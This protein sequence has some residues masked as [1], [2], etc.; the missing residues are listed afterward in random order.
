MVTH[1]KE[2]ALNDHEFEALLRGAQNIDDDLQSQE[3]TFVVYV[4][5][6]LGLRIGELTHMSSDWIN[7]RERMLEIPYR[8]DCTRGKD[9]GICGMC[10]QSAV[11]RA[12][13]SQLSLA[14]ARLK[15][16]QEQLLDSISLPGELQQQ[17]ETAHMLHI[18]SSLTEE[19]LERQIEK[20]LET[21]ATVDDADEVRSAL[22]EI[23]RQHQQDVQLTVDEAEDM[24]W[25]A[26]TENA[27]RSVPFA[28]APAVELTVEEYFDRFD[29]WMLSHSGVRRRLTKALQHANGL[30]EESTTPHGLRSTAASHVAGKGLSAPALKSMFGWANLSTAR[31]YITSSPQNTSRQLSQMQSR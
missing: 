30:D 12:E 26:K 23:A 2:Y 16:M 9:G 5:G 8:Q 27:A 4:L 17:L 1:S 11:Q 15:A 13:Y 7:H 31:R 19:S 10:R 18:N 3:A 22:D 21:A 14:E 20:L 25:R 28:W 29:R 24:M 6:R